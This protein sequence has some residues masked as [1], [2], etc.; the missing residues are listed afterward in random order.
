M[1][2]MNVALT[3]AGTDPTGGAGVMADLKSF[4]AREV[5]GMAVIT[6]VLAQNTCGVQSIADLGLEMLDAQLA[7]V[8]SDIQPDAIKTGMIAN[9]DMMA[10]IKR[11]LPSK[12]PYVLDPVMVATSGDILIDQTAQIQLKQQM[13]PLATIITPNLPEAEQLVEFRIESEAD[14]FRAGKVLL[15]ELGVNAAVIKGGHFTC[16]EHHVK[17]ATDYLFTREGNFQWASPKI[18]TCHTH[19]TGCT[20]SAVI[21][22]ELAKGRS[23]VEAVATAKR[24]I[25]A[26]IQHNPQLGRGNG[27]VNHVVYRGE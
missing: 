16:G 10:V 23:I 21:T 8:F 17:E 4:Q 20:F 14:I 9:A 26:A 2:K 24:F 15:N 22:A 6:S 19:G 25:T 13:L 18:D 3:I 12:V 5:Y 27:P 1:A 7:S 11:Y